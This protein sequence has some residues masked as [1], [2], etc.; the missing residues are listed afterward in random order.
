VQRDGLRSF[1]A[2]LHPHSV[3][4]G[5]DGHLLIA[6]LAHDV[7]R[8]LRRLLLREPQRV[9]LHLRF[10]RRSHLLGHPEKPVRRHQPFQRLMRPLEIVP[11]DVEQEL[12]LAVLVAGKHRAGEKFVPQGLPE[13]LHLSQGLRMLRPRLEVADPLPPQ[14]LLE[15]GGPPPGRVLPAVV[16]QHLFG[17]PILRDRLVQRLAHQEFLLVAGHRPAHDEAGVV[18]HEAAEVDPLVPAQE[19]SEDVR[20]PELVR[21]CPF[22]A[23]GPRLRSR[24]LRRRLQQLRLVQH[25]PHLRLADRQGLE[26]L[27]HVPDPPGAVL[28]VGLLQRQHRFPPRI[29][30]LRLPLRR[31]R[32]LGEQRLVSALRV[33]LSPQGHRGHCQP[34][35]P[36]DVAHRGSG[37]ELLQHLQLQLQRVC[38]ALRCP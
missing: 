17:H 27:Q 3:A 13:S 14:F 16:S 30:R 4:G 23:P 33:G 15:A 7:E 38:L 36:A 35:G 18:V 25:A 21:L 11:I 8:L 24:R 5:R 26:P 6:Q 1:L 20:L 22:E 28:R 29:V 9:L 31:S 2:K 10:H 34:E 37:L 19:E 12:V 32:Y